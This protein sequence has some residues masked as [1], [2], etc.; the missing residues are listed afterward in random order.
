MKHRKIDDTIVE[1]KRFSWNLE[2]R[3]RVAVGLGICIF[4]IYKG[5]LEPHNFPVGDP[6]NDPSYW[7]VSSGAF[8]VLGLVA[9][10][11][12]VFRALG[13]KWG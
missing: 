11:T 10:L 9:A 1:M 4:A 3:L 7:I 6:R 13:K 5:F 12:G 8:V 2:A